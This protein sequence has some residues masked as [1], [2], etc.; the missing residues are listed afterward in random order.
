MLK[1]VGIAAYL[2]HTISS[3]DWCTPLL[4]YPSTNNKHLRD[5]GCVEADL[6][7]A[8]FGD[9]KFY[10]LNKQGNIENS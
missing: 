6:Q 3:I 8:N 1:I 2:T 4:G 10:K 5:R 9:T 7:T